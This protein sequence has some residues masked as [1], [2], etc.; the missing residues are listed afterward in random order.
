MA[1][2]IAEPKSGNV[3]V[4][5][6]DAAA[7]K[8][9]A[10][11]RKKIDEQAR[12]REILAK[13]KA[14]DAAAAEEAAAANAKK[15]Q[16]SNGADVDASEKKTK[17]SEGETPSKPSGVDDETRL[18]EMLS[19]KKIM[20]KKNRRASKGEDPT[21]ETAGKNEG[22]DA[23]KKAPHQS[24]GHRRRE[25]GSRGGGRDYR[26]DR[27]QHG[28]GGYY[29]DRRRDDRGWRNNNDRG[30]YG[31]GRDNYWD[32]RGRGGGWRDE[33]RDYGGR[34]G[35]QH[36]PDFPARD[37]SRGRSRSRSFSRS[38][39]GSRSRSYSSSDGSRSSGSYS[40]R[41]HSRSYSRSVS[42]SPSRDSHY[43]E[44]Q[45]DKKRKRSDSVGNEKKKHR[46]SSSQSK[47]DAENAL[48]KDQRTVL[49]SQLVMKADDY[50]IRR[51]FKRKVGVK[52]NDVILLRDKR[53]GRHK[54]I[55]Y[56]E[57]GN[58]EDV[59]TALEVSGK[60][61]DFQRFPVL[62]KRTE[63]EKNVAGIS[64]VASS[65]S[66]YQLTA[67][68]KR[69]EAQK[70]YV[71]SI[72]RAV[73][74]AQLYSLFSQFGKLDNVLLQMDMATGISKGFAFLSYADPKDANLAIQTMSGQMLAGRPL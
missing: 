68:G 21:S 61:P 15:A 47:G 18:R 69:I 50:D 24:N 49:V 20:H 59:D 62:V 1:D 12:I 57:L 27:Q 14:R 67:D 34:G 52:V 71:G 58:L 73:T 3:A 10:D 42:R 55:A 6:T 29:D 37:R 22:S 5:A 51:Y 13:K 16:S 4:P 41:S 35:Y 70:V 65:D 38:S 43:S 39:S 54:G 23:D 64:V 33:R 8:Q 25:H 45:D 26:R 46:R 48:T 56:V 74:Q 32:G 9:A 72:D 7:A 36:Q 30:G 44:T 28:R 31:R 2:N 17:K 66:P 60:T 63:A 11:H 40:S 19:K 53:T